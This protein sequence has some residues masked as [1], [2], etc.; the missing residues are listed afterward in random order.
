MYLDAFDNRINE[1]GATSD[2]IRAIMKG[3]LKAL[4]AQ[5]KTALAGATDT[6]TRRHLDDAHDQIT[7]IL[8][9][10]AMRTPPA[11]AA[12]G[13]GRRGGGAGNAGSTQNGVMTLDSSQKYDWNH[14]PFLEAPTTCWPDR[15]I[16]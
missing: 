3:E 15:I 16:K 7:Q 13:A 4:D 11:A 14:D 10:R 2:E 6:A 1:N 5:I 12:G 9:P 8:D